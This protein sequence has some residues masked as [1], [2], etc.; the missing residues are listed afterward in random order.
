MRKHRQPEA[1]KT[2]RHERYRASCD[3]ELQQISRCRHEK[4]QQRILPNFCR[5]GDQRRKQRRENQTSN[6]RSAAQSYFHP[7]EKKP[8]EQSSGEHRGQP[9]P[10]LRASDLPPKIKQENKQRR[11]SQGKACL[12]SFK[13][14]RL[15]SHRYVQG[16][17]GVEKRSRCRMHTKKQADR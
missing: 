7:L 1:H 6:C 12:V 8:A 14:R 13:K 5:E 16:F 11:M 17:I 2:K 3:C 4:E 9:Q 15:V 10:K